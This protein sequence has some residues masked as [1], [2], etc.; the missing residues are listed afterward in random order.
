[1]ETIVLN[2][3]LQ[4]QDNMSVVSVFGVKEDVAINLALVDLISALS[5]DNPWGARQAAATKLGYIGDRKALPK[6]IEMLPGDPFWMV[7]QAII[8]A[9]QQIGDARAIPVLKMVAENDSY[10]IV[11][12]YAAK[13]IERISNRQH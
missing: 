6:L 12:S 11:R 2:P 3:S 8:Q 1:M 10:A 5:V 13:A 4:S 9:M 7:R